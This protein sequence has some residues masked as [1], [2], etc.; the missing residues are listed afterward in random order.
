MAFF[1]AGSLSPYGAPILR[2][3]IIT[4]SVVTDVMDSV[5]LASGFA[6]LGTTGSLVF[7]H[8]MSH[9]SQNGVGLLTTGVA[10]AEIGSY[11]ASFTAAANNQT[12]GR[13]T[14]DVDI[15]KETLYSADLDAAIG[16]TAASAQNGSKIDIVNEITLDESTAAAAAAQYNMWGA[17]AEA[18]TRAIVNI[19]ES[20]VFGV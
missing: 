12:V 1:K 18:P 20:Q 16:T 3:A 4:N 2:R 14:V 17:D 8:V 5:R 15:A 9:S 10:G 6:A 19:Y 11:V 13:V 7:G